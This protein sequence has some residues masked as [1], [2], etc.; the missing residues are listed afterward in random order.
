MRIAICGSHATGK[1]TLL[2]ELTR[3]R[4]ELTL[5][6]EPYFRLVDAGHVFNHPPSIEDFEQLF[7]DAIATFDVSHA[8]SVAFDRSPAD[9]LAY[10]TALQSDTTLA[11]RIALTRDAL[12]A[13]DLV[14]FVPIE[15]RDV[16]E[17]NEMPKLRRHVDAL[18]REM[19]VEQTWGF[20]K[21]ELEV[22][23]TPCERAQMVT[24]YLD[25]LKV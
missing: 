5:I 22:C 12:S 24:D 1:S 13:L 10:L 17:T 20:V 18:L 15:K 11:E 9:Y 25:A 8:H 6:E 23:G 2:H 21:P 7:D 3:T 19:L 4:P 14:V 16:I